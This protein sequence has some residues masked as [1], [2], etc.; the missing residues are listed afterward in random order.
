M[1]GLS[2][3]HEREADLISLSSSVQDFAVRLLDP[4]KSKDD[5][6]AFEEG[7]DVVVDKAISCHSKKVFFVLI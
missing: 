4:I 3:G 2:K 7:V 6:H 5:F 1:A